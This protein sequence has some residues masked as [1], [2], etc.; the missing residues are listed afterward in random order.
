MYAHDTHIIYRYIITVIKSVYEFQAFIAI[1]S[2]V[3]N[4]ENVK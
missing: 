3:L 1:V 2:T 4:N